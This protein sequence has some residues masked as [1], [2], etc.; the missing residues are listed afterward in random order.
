MAVIP[1]FVQHPSAPGSELQ[2]IFEHHKNFALGRPLELVVLLNPPR[3]LVQ[4]RLLE[5]PPVWLL[6]FQLEWL[7]ASLPGFP[8]EWLLGFPQ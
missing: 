4:H 5:L 8:P 6:V 7:P 3:F 2:G 1:L